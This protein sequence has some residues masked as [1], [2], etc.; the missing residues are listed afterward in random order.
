M[1][2]AQQLEAEGFNCEMAANAEDGLQLLQQRLVE[3]QP[4]HGLLLDWMLP[5]KSGATVME[6]LMNNPD[7][8]SL[9]IMIFTERPDKRAY[10]LA[11][12]R[13]NN[14]IQLKREQNLLAF[15][16]RKFLHLSANEHSSSPVESLLVDMEQ[17]QQD[18]HHILLVDDSLT[19]L[20]KYQA[21]LEANGF[22]VSTATN[23]AEALEIAQNQPLDLA[24]IDYLMPNGN[25]DE[26]TRA[27]KHNPVTMDLTVVIHSQRNDVLEQ[28]LE[29]GAI[30]LIYKDDPVHVFLM[31]IR[32]ILNVIAAQRQASQLK[33]F[34]L[35]ADRLGIGLMQSTQRENSHVNEVI[36]NFGQ[37]KNEI[38]EGR[39]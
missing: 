25:G 22:Q 17:Q 6:E 9:A 20:A 19:V 11:S 18:K 37:W 26:L 31:R 7:F 35:A 36:E 4:F 10:E 38:E 1:I 5:G 39:R 34:N 23:M 21:L 16:L 12:Q 8:S 28:A 24:I 2:T 13:P 32:A 14:D 29:A 33:L 30:D 3:G 27:L 15:R